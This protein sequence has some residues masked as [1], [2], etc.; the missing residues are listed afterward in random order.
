MN[1]IEGLMF[2]ILSGLVLAVGHILAGKWETVGWLIGGVPVGLFWSW[3]M[4]C[5]ARSVWR[6][7]RQSKRRPSKS[8]SRS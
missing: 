8:K 2:M 5:H 1:L 6:E 3:V 4:F 7:S